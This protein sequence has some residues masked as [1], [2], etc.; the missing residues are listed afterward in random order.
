MTSLTVWHFTSSPVDLGNSTYAVLYYVED[1]EE[2]WFMQVKNVLFNELY[3]ARFEAVK[4]KYEIESNDGV[5][6]GVKPLKAEKKATQT[7]A[8]L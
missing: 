4:E 1:G 6:N 8:A 3:E 7:Q 5:L 2:T